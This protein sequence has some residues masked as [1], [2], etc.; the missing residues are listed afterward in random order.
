[1]LCISRTQKIALQFFRVLINFF[2]S[3]FII[4]NVR[5]NII[6]I[7]EK[8]KQVGFLFYN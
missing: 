6:K 8:K 5:G 2:I 1:M 4:L 3:S 7:E